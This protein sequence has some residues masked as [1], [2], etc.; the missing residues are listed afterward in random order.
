MNI[1]KKSGM[2]LAPLLLVACTVNEVDEIIVVEQDPT[3][4]PADPCGAE[5]FQQFVGEQSPMISLPAGTVFRHYRSGD[6]V[7]ADLNPN[8]L[9]FEYDRTGTLVKVSCG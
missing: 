7:T 9:N 5:N 3:P 6:P 8:R 4:E 2:I 1:L